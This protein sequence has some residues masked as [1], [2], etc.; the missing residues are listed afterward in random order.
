MY[1]SNGNYEAFARPKKPKDVDYKSAY[2]VGSGL[3]SL[4]AA[5]FL[6]RDGQMK[7]S[8]IH[9]LEE[10]PKPGGSLDGADIPMKGYVVRGGREMENHFECLWDLFRSIPSLE[11]DNA[12]VLD[13][14]YWLNKEDPNYS[15]CRVIEHCGQ[16]L[17][18][19]GDFTLTKQA[20]KEI[21]DLCL[22]NE[23]DLNDV[24]ITDVFSDDFFNSNFWIYWKTMFAFEPWH[25]AMEM[26]RYLMRFVHHIG[27]LADFS[28][29]KF[30]KYNQYESLVLPLVDYLQFHGVQFE[31]GVKVE[32]IK[33]DVTT[34]QKI[35]REMI[36]KRQGH[37][38]I[39][40]LTPNDLVF[41]T[42]GSI[43]ESSTYG[44][45]DT[46][47]PPTHEPGGSWQLWQNLAHQSPEFGN[48]EKFFKA[49]P[50][51]SWFV[52]ATST[53]NNK[54]IIDTIERLCKRDPLAGKTVTGGIITVN[55]SSWQM[56]F[57]VNRQQ[58]FKGQPKDEVTSWIYA[59]YSDVN[60][61]YINKPITECSGQ[62]ICQEWL[63]HMG[64]PV[65][66]IEDLAQY[67][68]NTIPVYM[69]YITAYFMP[70]AQGDRP[71]VV[72]HQSCNLA[73][74]GNFAE[75]ER[76]TVFTTEYSVRTAMEAVYQLL[77]I[78][79]GVPEVVGTPF[80]IRV[81]MDAVYQLN[82]RKDLHAITEHN[83]I[84]KLAL[85]GFLKKIK[86]T[87]VETLLKDHHLL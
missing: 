3:A 83:P 46:P 5:S 34:S 44:D 49:I 19:D 77:D 65:E 7:G 56:S 27:G 1:Y 33:V 11:I 63:Y 25:S 37:N 40:T 30:T 21:L 45:N 12:S 14:F 28:A 66:E 69:P 16:E 15:R 2:L 43:T 6:I 70:R 4:A 78:D 32:N 42:N 18:T 17:S 38:D 26:R 62:E 51:K 64:V 53:T 54:T 23:D 35:A 86:G 10:L 47:A 67:Q 24:T 73:F 50:Q 48:P 58:Q 85:S 87:Y 29:L 8:N 55:D 31:Y 74:I 22:M 20:I 36:I 84:Q 79:R 57:T 41:V 72:P 9:I 71:L 59:L 39:I 52:S 60:G 76:D 82:D 61:D 13:E 75:T 68:S 81:L 80:D